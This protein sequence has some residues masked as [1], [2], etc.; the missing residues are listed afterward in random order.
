[1]PVLSLASAFRDVRGQRSL[2]A[3]LIRHGIGVAPLSSSKRNAPPQLSPKRPKLG[4]GRMRPLRIVQ[5]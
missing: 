3:F 1:V 2:Q 5:L 4:K